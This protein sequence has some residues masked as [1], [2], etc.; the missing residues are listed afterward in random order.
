MQYTRTRVNSHA[1]VLHRVQR[2]NEHLTNQQASEAR[3]LLHSNTH[4]SIYDC[5]K[6]TCIR[7]V[8]IY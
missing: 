2:S 3:L 5:N 7:R 4:Q 8:S 1:R 6:S